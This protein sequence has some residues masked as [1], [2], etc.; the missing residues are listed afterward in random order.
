MSSLNPGTGYRTPTSAHLPTTHSGEDG[1]DISDVGHD[2]EDGLMR[3]FWHAID[4]R[5]CCK[6]QHDKEDGLNRGFFWHTL[7]PSIPE[8]DASKESS[9]KRILQVFS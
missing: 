6:E 7:D 2:M 4:L 8:R 1:S 5:K 9:M 3:I